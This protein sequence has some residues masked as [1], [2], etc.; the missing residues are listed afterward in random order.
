MKL[1]RDRE[2]QIQTHRDAGTETKDR[3]YRVEEKLTVR[4]FF[5]RAG[6]SC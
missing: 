2:G 3:V 1:V 4:G 5:V 6:L